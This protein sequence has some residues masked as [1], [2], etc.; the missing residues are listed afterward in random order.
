MFYRLS[1]AIIL[2]FTF[3]IT[4]AQVY[5]FPIGIPASAIFP[6]H[7]FL[8]GNKFVYYPAIHKH[9]LKNL[10]LRVEVIDDRP[11]MKLHKTNCSDVEFT[12]TS[13]FES[14]ECIYKLGKYADTLLKQSN[15]L[16]DLSSS[17]TLQIRLQGIDSRLIG[18]GYIVAHGLCQISVRYRDQTKIDVSGFSQGVYIVELRSGEKV[19]RGKFLKE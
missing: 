4:S 14:P 5:Y 15:A 1:L 17:D 7:G 11:K 19:L 16:L 3:Q 2:S 12:S 8:P 13:E 9:D 10:K 6:E 18:F